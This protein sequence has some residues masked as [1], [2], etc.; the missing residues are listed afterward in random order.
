LALFVD[1]LSELALQ[2]ETF[3]QQTRGLVERG[4]D[5]G[6]SYSSI[7]SGPLGSP[8]SPDLPSPMGPP[9]LHPAMGDGGRFQAGYP[10]FADPAIAGIVPPKAGMAMG[11]PNGWTGMATPPAT[12]GL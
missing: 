7:V 6:S 4:P 2:T 5:G 3:A 11:R 10:P 12:N 8:G 1:D 9:R